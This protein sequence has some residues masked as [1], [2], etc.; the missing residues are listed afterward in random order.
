[1]HCPKII[2][3]LR[4]F[5]SPPFSSHYAYQIDEILDDWGPLSWILMA[6][7]GPRMPTNILAHSI[8]VKEVVYMSRKKW[9]FFVF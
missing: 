7:Y 9:S 4:N 1:M 2:W 3:A 6:S 5:A 8:L